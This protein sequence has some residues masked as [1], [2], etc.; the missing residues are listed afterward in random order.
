MR[1]H[2]GVSNYKVKDLEALKGD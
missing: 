1:T 2:A